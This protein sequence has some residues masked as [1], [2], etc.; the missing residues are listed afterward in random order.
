MISL[1][2]DCTKKDA[3]NI[4]NYFIDVLKEN[5]LQGEQVELRGFGTFTKI[6]REE[7]KIFSNISK[8]KVDVPAYSTVL[9]KPSK[10]LKIT[11]GD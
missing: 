3:L 1:R 10:T 4:I 11:K 5:V 9:F 7:R 8:K 2:A 6:E